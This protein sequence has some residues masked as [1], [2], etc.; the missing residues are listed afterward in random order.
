MKRPLLLLP[1]LLALL[2]AANAAP[3]PLKWGNLTVTVTPRP[4]E[5]F[6]AEAQ[7]TVKNGTRTVLT[8]KGWNVSAELQPLRPG[9]LP[10]LVLTGYSG[11][12]HCC[13]T[14]YVFTQDT[15][16][17]E[18][19]AVIEAG[20]YGLRF[21]DLNGDGTKELLLASDTLAYYDWS[22]AVSPALLTVLGW[23]GV[24]LADRTRA[25]AYVPAQEAARNLRELLAGL[26]QSGTA[27]DILK[28]QLGGYYA[29]MLLAGQGTQAEQMLRTQV[30][31]K[32]APLRDWFRQH[33]TGLINAAYAQ[34]EGRVQ[35]VDS[36]TYPLKGPNEP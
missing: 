33:R 36:A 34:P 24:R 32:S 31:T 4:A 26:Q 20:N 29:N 8:V 15:G 7:A 3:Q 30:F 21:T 5:N 18:N 10:E 27:Q 23:D 13:S 28:A 16:S 25:Y 12:A 19:L 6:D 9:G 11:G 2:P 14:Y 22:Y 17:V 35:A 1:V